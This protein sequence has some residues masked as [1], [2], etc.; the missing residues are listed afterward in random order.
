MPCWAFQHPTDCPAQTTKRFFSQVL[1]IL[2]I[3]VVVTRR[4][5]SWVAPHNALDKHPGWLRTV[6]WT[7]HVLRVSKMNVVLTRHVAS[8]TLPGRFT[9]RWGKKIV[10]AFCI[11]PVAPRIFLNVSPVTGDVVLTWPNCVE[12]DVVLPQGNTDEYKVSTNILQYVDIFCSTV[13][14]CETCSPT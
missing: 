10:F 3:N 9:V 7:F 8:E 11:L 14:S 4:L 2:D 13:F 6:R 1:N 12:F 5:A